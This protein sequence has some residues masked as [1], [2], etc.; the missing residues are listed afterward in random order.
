MLLTFTHHTKRSSPCSFIV[1]DSLTA[2][3]L[4]LRP[5][6]TCFR[7]LILFLFLYRPHYVGYLVYLTQIVWFT[8][9]VIV[10]SARYFYVIIIVKPYFM[11]SEL[12]NL[13]PTLIWSIFI[14]SGSVTTVRTCG[15]VIWLNDVT[16][17]PAVTSHW[18][19]TDD[20][21]AVDAAT[22]IWQCIAMEYKVHG[23]S[24]LYPDV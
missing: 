4:A 3:N 23:T 20:V 15:S 12:I 24:G 8:F 2:Q 17:C 5:T 19:H 13:F 1:Y 16:T 18:H 11:Y 9:I 10:R 21:D 7:L 14:V 6:F 22:K